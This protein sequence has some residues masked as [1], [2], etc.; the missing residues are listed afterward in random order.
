MKTRVWV[1]FGA[2]LFLIPLQAP[3]RASA[4]G[5][6][7]ARLFVRSAPSLLKKGPFL[8]QGKVTSVLLELNDAGRTEIVI[9]ATKG[10]CRISPTMDY[11]PAA[12]IAA[13]NTI[14][15]AVKAG[16]EIRCQIDKTLNVFLGP[17]DKDKLPVSYVQI[18][19]K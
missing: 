19:E 11:P 9:K 6:M 4:A 2:T 13:R 1:T 5:S 17:F 15:A 18:A 12:F 7:E 16:G 10:K 14:V 3:S 8:D